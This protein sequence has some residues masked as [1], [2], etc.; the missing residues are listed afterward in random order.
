MLDYAWLLLVFPALGTLIF[1]LFGRKLG[2]RAV[3][4]LAPAMVALSFGLAVWLF[5]TLLG[6]PAEERSHEI[7]LWSWMT[8][9]GFHVDIALLI[10]QLSITMALVVTG[11]GFLIH[12]Y[13]AGYM[14][15]DPR[16]P[17]FFTYMNFF[18][19][20]MLT[21]VLANNYLLLY[22]G[23]EGVGLASYLLIGFW[24]DKPSAADAGKKAFLV[25]RIG[26]FGLALAIMFLWTGLG[27]LQFSQVFQLAP[28]KWA[29]GSTA[30]VVVTMLMLLAATGKSAQIPLFVWLPDAMEGPTPVSALIHAATMV[31][32]GVY[33]VA[34]SAVLF[35]LAPSSAAWVAGIG[36]ATAL[37]AA[38]IAITQTDLKRI[39]A[40]STIS[41]LG[42]MF[43][44]IGVGGY[45][46]GIFH[47][48]THAFFKALLFLGAGS[49]MH[50]LD[51]ELDIRKMGNLRTK[52]PTTYWT[53]LIG[54][55]ALA[56]I[57][58]L[59][60]FFSKDEIL[61]DAWLKSPILWIVGF[62]TAILTAIYSFR[63]VFTVFWGKERDA[64]L[65]GHAH[66]SPRVMTIPLVLL[67]IGSA[68][69]GYIGLPRLSL[70]G[71]WLEPVFVSAQNNAAKAAEALV[72]SPI[73]WVLLVGSGLVAIGGAYV[74][75][76]A[77]VV[78]TGIP[79]RVRESLGGFAKLVE[80]KYYIDEA[81]YT[82]FVKPA[83]DVAGWLAATFDKRVID[84][85][86]NGIGG[87]FGWVGAQARKLQ[88][89]MVG[90]Y[91]LSIM[92]GAVALLIWLAIK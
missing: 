86:V 16:V 34:R 4:I 62:I 47:L 24:F 7:V 64:K 11:I 58:L 65:Y 72:H 52:M 14:H 51:G 32:A 23:W 87:G 81:Y 29:V 31:T 49:V 80:H 59:S 89:G 92:V 19:L 74:A 78:N 39:L 37:F 10:D 43:L 57:P 71:L 54:A 53:F 5:V 12:V 60:G 63:M 76:R 36:V 25:N 42:F 90:L 91:A 15:D 69:V 13:S 88:S 55:A 30:V 68:L 77:Y 73:E 56:G 9:G 61:W 79:E 17:R 2:K 75:Y 20:M 83:R 67:A 28:E 50:G 3:S 35:G 40:Y 27:T 18:I 1:A 38:T 26:D 22:V 85:V 41:Q 21:L 70:F 44:A 48:V 33:L 66:E 82:I 45:V 6:M 8:T 84:G 46:A